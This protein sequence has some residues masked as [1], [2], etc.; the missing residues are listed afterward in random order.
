MLEILDTPYAY[1]YIDPE[2][3]I[4]YQ[5]W[6]GY[7]T[8]ENFTAAIDLTVACFRKYDL[9]YIVSDTTDQAVLAKEGSDYAASVMPELISLGLKKVAFVL[10]KSS[11]TKHSV[12]NFT[13]AS[14]KELIGHFATRPEA[15]AWINK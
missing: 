11:F 14:D 4:I 13:K 1:F 6:K 12:N 2:K 5:I 15:E 3:A 10:P 7:A 9:Q 8:V